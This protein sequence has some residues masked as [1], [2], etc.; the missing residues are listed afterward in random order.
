[1]LPPDGWRL[2][3]ELYSP[4]SN[5]ASSRPL[6][7]ELAETRPEVA[8]NPVYRQLPGELCQTLSLLYQLTRLFL[9]QCEGVNIVRSH[10]A[11]Q[12]WRVCRIKTHPMGERP[13]VTESLEIDDTFHIATR[14]ADSNH[15]RI[16]TLG[17]QENN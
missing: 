7:G 10:V 9:F 16:I 5:K 11:K 15:A 2:Q 3:A 8:C 14:Y 4:A 6:S 17:E 12:H 13:C 1:M